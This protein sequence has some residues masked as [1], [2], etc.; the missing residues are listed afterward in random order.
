MSFG[1]KV[2]DFRRKM[3]LVGEGNSSFDEA[4]SLMAEGDLLGARE[5]IRKAKQ[6]YRLAKNPMKLEEAKEL[7]DEL[8]YENNP[9]PSRWDGGCPGCG[10]IIKEGDEAEFYNRFDDEPSKDQWVVH[11][12]QSCIDAAQARPADF[13]PVCPEHGSMAFKWGKWGGF[14][15]CNA[16]VGGGWCKE[17]APRGQGKWKEYPPK[18]KATRKKKTTKTSTASFDVDSLLERARD[19]FRSKSAQAALDNDELE[20]YKD[21]GRRLKDDRKLPKLAMKRFMKYL[22][23]CESHSGMTPPPVDEPPP[24]PRS[25]GGWKPS[26]GGRHGRYGCFTAFYGGMCQLCDEP[27]EEGDRI[28]FWKNN[29]VGIKVHEEC[30]ERDL[31]A[32]SSFTCKVC[33]ER[34]AKGTPIYPWRDQDPIIWVHE[35]CE[36]GEIETITVPEKFQ[37][38]NFTP[39]EY[40][41]NIRDVYTSTDSHM[42]I[43]AK[44]GSGKSTT[45]EWLISTTYTAPVKRILLTAFNRSIAK[46]LQGRLVTGDGIPIPGASASTLNSHG[47]SLVRA[48]RAYGRVALERNKISLL[49]Q[50]LFPFKEEDQH[51]LKGFKGEA[52]KDRVK[53]NRTMV[54]LLRK[55][56][57]MIRA[58]LTPLDKHKEIV[59]KYKIGLGQLDND[60]DEQIFY[61]SL[62]K[63]LQ[64]SI[65]AAVADDSPKIIDFLDQIYLAVVERY[66]RESGEKLLPDAATALLK[67]IN[68]KDA[69]VDVLFV[70]ETQDL[71]RVQQQMALYTVGKKGRLVAVGDRF[72]SIYAFSG[73]DS[74][75][76]TRLESLLS[77][78]PRGCRVENLSVTFRCPTAVVEEA[79]RILETQM[80]LPDG[81]MVQLLDPS[82]HSTI[83]AM[84]GA[85]EGEVREVPEACIFDST[86]PYRLTLEKDAKPRIVR[87][88]SHVPT[89][90][91][92]R[93]NAPLIGA[94][95]RLIVNKIP[96]KIVGRDISRSLLSYIDDVNP[97]K[98]RA[99]NRDIPVLLRAINERLIKIYEKETKLI[100]NGEL[101]EDRVQTDSPFALEKDQAAAI[102]MVICGGSEA[103]TAGFREG[104]DG[105]PD[106]CDPG[107]ETQVRNVQDLKKKIDSLF[108]GG[109]CPQ[110]SRHSPKNRNQI[111]DVGDTNCP[112]CLSERGELVEI[113]KGAHGVT[114]SSVHK[115]KGLEA[116]QIYILQPDTLGDISPRRPGDPPP[117][118]ED[119]RQELHMKYVAVTRTK[120][121]KGDRDSG[122]LT[123]LTPSID[124]PETAPPK[125]APPPTG[126]PTK[127]ET[128]LAGPTT[129]PEGYSFW[130]DEDLT[131]PLLRKDLGSKK[132][133]NDQVVQKT[134]Q[135]ALTLLES[136]RPGGKH[137]RRYKGEVF[138]YPDPEA[139]TVQDLLDLVDDDD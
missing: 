38:H 34:A 90:I 68:Y 134:K 111:Q 12:K 31:P 25:P 14:W 63:L 74:E 129:M 113:D 92:C 62:P 108:H 81:S 3:E 27:W 102:C 128:T 55:T 98:K 112:T 139:T 103:W 50:Q 44:A 52:L 94:A 115:S 127:P 136:L 114:L 79:Q 37:P 77:G 53:R 7:E 29:E 33:G 13:D 43:E 17:K 35:G 93:R 73:A 22:E 122:I 57:D 24:P 48:K 123:Y 65:E 26:R 69:E 78:T 10:E 109:I 64:M 42:I 125:I 120:F 85:P 59:E 19:T 124:C 54:R 46:E 119:Q 45:L 20:D 8:L 6:L 87:G 51:L 15:A 84:D 21:L 32:K 96:A 75:S 9:F 11:N 116:L 72:Q 117:E 82:R 86:S 80:V 95:L 61:D 23:R 97:G 130:K 132:R 5:Q 4:K 36:L 137:S 83:E 49:A 138:V 89:M 28:C 99:K 106:S 18:P 39:S 56:V 66:Q 91:L 118:E 67:K 126:P 70:D 105:Q 101:D 110:D 60:E 1:K 133:P 135:N 2:S 30:A 131:I 71:N 88:K 58:N 40:Q 76:M 104:D 47:F 41:L 107:C 100:R 16:R 121:I